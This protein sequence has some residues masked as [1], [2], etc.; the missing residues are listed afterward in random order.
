MSPSEKITPKSRLRAVLRREKVDRP[1]VCCPGGMMNAAIVEIVGDCAAT[2]PDAHFDAEKMATLSLAIAEKTGFENIALPFC[3]TVE[4]EALGSRINPGSL[5]CEPKVA[6]EA[7]P[8]CADVPKWNVA[9]LLTHGRVPLILDATRRLAATHGDLPVIVSLSGPVSTAASVVDPPTYFKELRKKPA[10]A[11]RVTGQ[12]TA[13]LAA[14]ARAAVQ[15]GADVIAIGDPSATGD[16]LGPKL[17]AEF[18]VPYLHE[19]VAAIHAAGAPAMVHICGNTDNCR[20]HW[21]AIGADA[22]SVDAM[23]NLAKLKNEFP[24]A[25]ATMGNLSTFLL[26]FSDAE[27]I[28][29][30]AR[31]LVADG[32]DIIAPACGLS[33]STKLAAIRA[34]TDAVRESAINN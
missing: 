21:V 5:A 19:L 27:K 6:A 14:Y 2:L 34:M 10:E 9:E 26:E 23:I 30:R 16:I 15:A 7:Y 8:S 29:A 11:R 25:F 22:V 20:Q 12:V 4:P 24:A 3:M 18:A 13:F 17:F 32:I 33:T 31:Q 28:A 1:P